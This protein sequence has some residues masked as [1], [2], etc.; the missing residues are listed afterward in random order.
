MQGPWGRSELS[1]FD[2]QQRDQCGCSRGRQGECSEVRAG[3]D[4]GR[5]YGGSLGMALRE[6]AS[7]YLQG[8]S[9]CVG[10]RL[11]VEGNSEPGRRWL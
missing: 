10:N 2:K 9:D 5:L 7:Q 3:G 4:K 6:M 8:P 11:G 1:K